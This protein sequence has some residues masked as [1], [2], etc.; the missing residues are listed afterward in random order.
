MGV[1][2]MSTRRDL[3]R[4][5]KRAEYGNRY[6]AALVEAPSMTPG[7][8]TACGETSWVEAHHPCARSQGGTDGPLLDLCKADHDLAH[9]RKLH[10]RHMDRWEY[11]R[12]ANATKY[13]VALTMPGWRAL[14]DAR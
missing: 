1:C 9:A 2:R 13:E 11:L 12:T 8:C 14:G 7:W 3:I 5:V 6:L 4:A 10:F